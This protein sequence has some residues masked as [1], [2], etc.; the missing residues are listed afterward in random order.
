MCPATTFIGLGGGVTCKVSA[1]R[2][3]ERLEVPGNYINIYAK[4]EELLEA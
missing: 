3:L 2:S 1:A 4:E